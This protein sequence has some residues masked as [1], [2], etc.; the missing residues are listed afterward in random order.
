MIREQNE[1]YVHWLKRVVQAVREKKIDYDEMGN[2]LLGE[3]NVYCYDNLRKMFYALD[4]IA[5]KL[6]EDIVTTDKE[7]IDQIQK[8]KD[9]LFKETVKLRD[10]KR[11]IRND[12]R[13][14]A[15]FEN[16]EQVLID[17][18]SQQPKQYSSKNIVYKPD[19]NIVA[20]L[21]ISDIHYGIKVDNSVNQYDTD[22]AYFRLLSLIDK[23]IKYCQCHKVQVLNVEL[24][25]DLI[26]GCINVSNRVEQ[27]EDLMEQ[28]VEISTIL[29]NLINKLVENI[30]IVNV[31][32]TF[33]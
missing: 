15:R 19:N 24:L 10:K 7:L 1:S 5:D 12:L 30:P 9:D 8:E 2:C 11:E 31:Y 32:C 21:L 6:D 28:I 29:A 23:T 20:A 17:K 13:K 27:E 14:M 25:G 4:V 16:L 33:W 26:S 3:N 22:I 18:L